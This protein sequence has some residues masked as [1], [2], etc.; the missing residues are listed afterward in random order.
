MDV[1]RVGGSAMVDRHGD[2]WLMGHQGGSR[3][4][5]IRHYFCMI[6]VYQ[7]ELGSMRHGVLV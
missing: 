7:V 3:H 1:G 2:M 6:A 4:W 5:R